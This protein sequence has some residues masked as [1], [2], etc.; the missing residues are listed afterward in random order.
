MLGSHCHLCTT[1]SS[2]APTSLPRKEQL[3]LRLYEWVAVSPSGQE[4]VFFLYSCQTDK[5]HHSVV[6]AVQLLLLCCTCRG[7]EIPASSTTGCRRGLLAT[8]PEKN[9]G[10]SSKESLHRAAGVSVTKVR[11]EETEKTEERQ[12][13]RRETGIMIST[14]FYVTTKVAQL[15]LVTLHFYKNEIKCSA[16]ACW[17]QE[18]EEMPITAATRA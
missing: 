16:T 8:G 6:S 5:V 9:T 4:C 14:S 18:T 13:K 2:P 10:A 3:C 7:G 17:L 1:S 12:E 11:S 15:Y